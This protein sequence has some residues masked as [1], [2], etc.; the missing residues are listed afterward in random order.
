MKMAVIIALLKITIAIYKGTLKL[1]EWL[2]RAGDE[3]SAAGR[4]EM[5]NRE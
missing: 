2:R 3:L 5:E 1:Q 4:R